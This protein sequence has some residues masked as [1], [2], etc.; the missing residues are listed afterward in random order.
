MISYYQPHDESLAEVA[1]KYNVLACQICVWRKTFI[2][3]G[4]SGL[5]PHPKGRST[6]M[7]RPK[8]KIRQLEKQSEIERLRSELKGIRNSMTQSWRMTS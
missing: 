1:G 2:R 5:E 4:Y 6:K 3:D 8:K 7:K